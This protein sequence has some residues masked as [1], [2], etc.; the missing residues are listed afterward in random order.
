M[1]RQWVLRRRSSIRLTK[2]TVES[3]KPDPTRDRFIWDEDLTGFGLRVTKA[4]VKSYVVQYRVPGAR[5]ARR[6][7][8]AKVGKVTPEHARQ[9][10]RAMLA[11]VV[12]G[13]D[14][15]AARKESRQAPTVGEL[16]DRFDREHIA[17]RLKPKTARSYPRLMDARIRPRFGTMRVKDVTRTDV[18]RWHHKTRDTPVEANR[19]LVLF[20]K[21]MNTAELWGLREGVNPVQGVPKFSETPRER[22]LTADELYRLGKAIS[23]LEADPEQPLSP[24]LAH[25][26][27]LLLLTG[28][29]RDEVM[30]LKWDY[31]DLEQ[32]VIRLPDS[33]TGRKQVVLS[34]AAA[35]VL[36]RAPR[37]ADC[38]WV[39]P[40]T[41]RNRDK[42]R[43]HVVSPSRAWE[44]VKERASRDAGADAQALS[45]PGHRS[46]SGDRGAHQAGQGSQGARGA[47]HSPGPR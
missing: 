25:A 46:G 29:R 2:R 17:V 33:K 6:L 23:D 34:A 24:Y 41:R 10:A 44:R 43:S 35:E 16:L 12:R 30:T 26:F 38:D 9:T 19:S 18:A 22:Y 20:Q 4:G 15:A 14:P 7:T 1:A 42:V 37:E 8:V 40:S 5:L 36:K 28:M 47:G 45:E 13:V 21:I 11:D 39:V 31:V 32:G 27:R 3:A